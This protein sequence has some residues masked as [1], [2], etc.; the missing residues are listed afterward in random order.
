[1]PPIGF[2]G[3]T[4]ALG[5]IVH[6]TGFS[7]LKDILELKLIFIAITIAICLVKGF[8]LKWRPRLAVDL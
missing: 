5:S 1:M 4:R 2:D 7:S 3:G 6:T 8:T